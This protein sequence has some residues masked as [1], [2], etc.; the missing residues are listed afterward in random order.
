MFGP[1]RV[2]VKDQID[3][4]WPFEC[5][6]DQIQRAIGREDENDP[7]VHG[8]AVE[9]AEKNRLILALVDGVAIA[10]G[11]VHVVE[12][13]DAALVD[14]EEFLDAVAGASLPVSVRA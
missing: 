4:A 12:K 11:D 1:W 13:D 3:P 14:A 6:V 9:G 2:E 10:Q 8:D 7:F 5:P